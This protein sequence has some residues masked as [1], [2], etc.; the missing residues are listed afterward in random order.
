MLIKNLELKKDE[1]C[2]RDEL[3]MYIGDVHIGYVVNMIDKDR[4]VWEIDGIIVGRHKT[5]DKDFILVVEFNANGVDLLNKRTAT[6]GFTKRIMKLMGF[7]GADYNC[8]FWRN[9]IQNKD[10]KI[11]D[12]VGNLLYDKPVNTEAGELLSYPS[13]VSKRAIEIIHRFGVISTPRR[14]KIFR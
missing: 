7:K 13:K 5:M 1:G 6:A 10:G 4:G 2:V 14:R 8:R 3:A 9:Y 11:Y 12:I